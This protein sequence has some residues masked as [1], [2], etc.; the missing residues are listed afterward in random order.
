[1]NGIGRKPARTVPLWQAPASTST[2]WLVIEERV[3]EGGE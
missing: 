3:V 1:M 2:S